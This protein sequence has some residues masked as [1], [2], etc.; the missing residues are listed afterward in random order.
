MEGQVVKLRNANRKRCCD[1]AKKGEDDLT[2]SFKTF[3]DGI[4]SIT[5][6]EISKQVEEELNVKI[7]IIK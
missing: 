5:F 4:Q 1:C 2:F 3:R 6:S 7:R